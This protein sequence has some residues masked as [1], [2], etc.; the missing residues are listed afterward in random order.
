MGK[1][2]VSPMK[3]AV[4]KEAIKNGSIYLIF[5]KYPA[6]DA[7]GDYPGRVYIGLTTKKVSHR[8]SQH[9]KHTIEAKRRSFLY[10]NLQA[11]GLENF[12]C[13][14]LETG[15]TSLPKLKEREQHWIRTYASFTT[16]LNSS[17]GGEDSISW[18][19]K[20]N[21]KQTAETIA[22][23]TAKN[24]GQKRTPEQRANLSKGA[25]GKKCPQNIAK[26]KAR[27]GKAVSA[28]EKQNRRSTLAKGVAVKIRVIATNEVLEFAHKWEASEKLGLNLRQLSRI[29]TGERDDETINGYHILSRTY[30]TQV[31]PAIRQFITIKNIHTHARETLAGFKEVS[32][33]YQVSQRHIT[34]L[35]HSGYLFKQTYIFSKENNK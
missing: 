30:S 31:N 32:E 28:Q 25:M 17:E 8:W 21:M 15:I 33:K 24:R 1:R 34:R 20:F 13:I 2:T 18:N 11:L 9:K 16:G 26:N 7:T 22:N 10:Q 23:R 12:E 4:Q 35:I 5:Y 27:A 14:T 3:I 6:E 29:M 19:P